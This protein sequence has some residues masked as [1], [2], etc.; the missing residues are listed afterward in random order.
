[1]ATR[2][3]PGTEVEGIEAISVIAL[4]HR[5]VADT[6]I[7][8]SCVDVTPTEIGIH[9]AA[10]SSIGE[11]ALEHVQCRRQEMS[12]RRLEVNSFLSTEQTGAAFSRETDVRIVDAHASLCHPTDIG[13]V[14]RDVAIDIV[15]IV[16]TR[17]E[18]LGTELLCLD[19]A[20]AIQV[21]H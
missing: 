4:S 21:S 9:R 18:T 6:K 1:M 2:G 14:E 7:A 15:V 10:I 19:V 5:E 3:V 20:T 13:A 16:E 17:H 11:S 12:N 8:V